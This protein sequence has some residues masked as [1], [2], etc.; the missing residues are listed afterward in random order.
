MIREWMNENEVYSYYLNYLYPYIREEK[1]FTCYGYGNRLQLYYSDYLVV[2]F[3][4]RNKRMFLQPFS[5]PKT[6][7]VSAKLRHEY[8]K[9]FFGLQGVKKPFPLKEVNLLYFL[10]LLVFHH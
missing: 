8:D 4:V 10:Q 1:G 7:F 5:C 9:M 6:D 2:E 3:Y